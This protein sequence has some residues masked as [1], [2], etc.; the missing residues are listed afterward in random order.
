MYLTKP[1]GVF[2]QLLAL[3]VGVWGLALLSN[4]SWGSG[5]LVG[6]LAL[7]LLYLGGRPSRPS[8]R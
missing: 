2:V 3:P 4:G 7:S 6:L 8:R 1:A 5:C